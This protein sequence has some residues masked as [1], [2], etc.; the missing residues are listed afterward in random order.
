MASAIERLRTDLIGLMKDYF[1]N[2]ATFKDEYKDIPIVPTDI[3]YTD[4][5][6]YPFISYKVTSASDNATDGAIYSKEVVPSV[7]EGYEDIKETKTY[8]PKFIY[9]WNCYSNKEEESQVLAERLQEF[10]NYV[11]YYDLMYKD[12][13][14]VNIGKIQPRNLVL[15]MAYE[16]R[17]GFDVELRT[18]TSVSRTI[19]TIDT[20]KVDRTIE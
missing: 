1:D 15:N 16:Y 6:N 4:K 13:V 19:E 5:P 17:Y 18:V 8:Q 11:G 10:F 14:V 7:D 3:D 12:I 2:K 20:F 9:S